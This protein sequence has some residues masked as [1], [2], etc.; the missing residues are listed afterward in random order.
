MV[1]IS[2]FAVWADDPAGQRIPRHFLRSINFLAGF[3]LGR[4]YDLCQVPCRGQ[5]HD[6][7]FTI[8]CLWL[9]SVFASGGAETV[10]YKTA[11]EPALKVLADKPADWKAGEERPAIVLFS[12]DLDLKNDP[13]A[14]LR[15]AFPSNFR[16]HS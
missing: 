15:T 9:A 14:H 13:T 1:G 12:L 11:V 6:K 7:T 8:A 3:P 5:K 16:R 4:A 2:G 10:G